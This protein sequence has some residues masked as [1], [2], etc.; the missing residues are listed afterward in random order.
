MF[1]PAR[2]NACARRRYNRVLF[3]ESGAPHVVFVGFLPN[4]WLVGTVCGGVCGRRVRRF[5]PIRFCCCRIHPQRGVCAAGGGVGFG[6]VGGG[7]AVV[8]RGSP[9]WSTHFDADVQDFD[10]TRYLCAQE[11]IE[12]AKSGAATLLLSKFIPG[13]S[14]FAPPMAGAVGM[15][16]PTFLLFNF[17]GSLLWA[18]SGVALGVVFHQQ[19]NQLMATLSEFGGMAVVFIVALLELYVS[20]RLLRR[21]SMNR[22]RARI[23]KIQALELFDLLQSEANIKVLDVRGT[24]DGMAWEAGIA[25]A[26][27]V[28]MKRCK[29]RCQRLGARAMCWLLFALVPTMLRR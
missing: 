3:L 16:L 19:L 26:E 12:L 18:G 13:L 1:A 17:A 23:P 27:A 14:T 5:L 4:P 28:E 2:L 20:Y 22:L 29:R 25:G 21:W 7:F 8:L 11:R 15:R 24:V 10:F 6:V 9:L